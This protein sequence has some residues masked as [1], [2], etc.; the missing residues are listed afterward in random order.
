MPH[1]R[2][3]LVKCLHQDYFED[4]VYYTVHRGHTRI[5][6]ARSIP[7]ASD[8]NDI[9]FIVIFTYIVKIQLAILKEAMRKHCSELCAQCFELEM[10]GTV[11]LS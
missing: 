8:I 4:S 11:R 7:V 9:V 3:Y 1:R 2:Y 10:L 5:E 6:A